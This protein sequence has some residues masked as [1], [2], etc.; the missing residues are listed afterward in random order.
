MIGMRNATLKSTG[1]VGLGL[2]ED[3]NMINEEELKKMLDDGK[4]NVGEQFV[5]VQVIKKFD[6]VKG[7][8][9]LK[10]VKADAK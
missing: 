9:Q 2:G 10:Q 4:I 8:I 1:Y 7:E 6:V 5:K 3:I